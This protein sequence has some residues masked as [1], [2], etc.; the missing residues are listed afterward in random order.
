MASSIR[1][2]FTAMRAGVT[3]ALF[4]LLAGLGIEAQASLSNPSSSEPHAASASVP[5][6]AVGSAQIRNHSLLFK[7]LKVHEVPSY[8]EYKEFVA[9]I[10]SS[11]TSLD[12]GNLVHKVDVYIKGEADSTFMHRGDS[13]DNALKLDGLSPSQLVQGHG[14]VIT[15]NLTLGSAGADLF[16]L[17]GLLRVSASADP[18]GGSVN[19]T[20]T[21]TSSRPLMVNGDGKA[22][23]STIAAGGTDTFSFADGSVRPLQIVGEGGAQVITLTLSSFTGGVR[24]LVGQAIVG[25]P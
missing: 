12:A 23:G 22:A 8:K 25:T 9:T 18:A 19:V 16:A 4:G 14:Q 7:D 2:R 3:M 1:R 17:I 6:S 5:R 10:M 11:L 21:N 13:A 15:A 24:T 20:L